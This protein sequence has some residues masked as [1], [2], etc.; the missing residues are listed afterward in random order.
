[1]YFIDWFQ[2]YQPI[3]KE[4]TDDDIPRWQGALKTWVVP[5]LAPV[6]TKTVVGA[7]LAKQ[8][9]TRRVVHSGKLYNVELGY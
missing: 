6:R 2:K 7:R 4:G 5:P 9:K 3:L 1:M 8:E